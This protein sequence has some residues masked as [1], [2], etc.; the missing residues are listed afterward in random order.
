MKTWWKRELTRKRRIPY[1]PSIRHDEEDGMKRSRSL[2]TALCALVALAA[3]PLRAQDDP[4]VRRCASDD[5]Y[6]QLYQTNAEFREARK[7]LKSL[8]VAFESV[9]SGERTAP[10]RIPTV[11]HVVHHTPEQDV[12]MEQIQSQIDALNADYQQ[13]NADLAGVPAPYQSRIGNPRLVFELAVRDP[14]GQRTSGV[15]R[16]QTAETLFFYDGPK[17]EAVKSTERGGHDGWPRDRYL[18]LW[19]APLGDDLLGYASFPGEDEALDGVVVTTSAFGTM[20]TAR[21]PFDKGRTATHEV[22]HWLNLFH[23]WGD[24]RSACTGSD[25]VRDTP[26]QASANTRCPTFP[27]R[28]CGNRTNGDLFMNYMDYTDDACM[29]MFTKG[30]VVRMEATMAGSRFALTASDG[31]EPVP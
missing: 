1:R 5:R 30:Q 31:L 26:N 25:Q 19:V 27:R 10:L 9:R 18:N 29:F 21:P 6:Q 16:T 13:T 28:T 7:R 24:D 15:T 3:V 23:I 11:V 14:N 4:P 2:P 22:G 20:G 8:T 17:G 12:S